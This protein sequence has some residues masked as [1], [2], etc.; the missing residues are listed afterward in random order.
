VSGRQVVGHDPHHG[1][2][3]R[4]PSSDCSVK[5]ADT[6][7]AADRRWHPGHAHPTRPRGPRL[8]PSDGC[9]GDPASEPRRRSVI[10]RW[11]QAPCGAINCLSLIIVSFFPLAAGRPIPFTLAL[12]SSDLAEIGMTTEPHQGVAPRRRAQPDPDEATRSPR[13]VRVAA[14][15]NVPREP[16]RCKMLN[17]L[18]SNGSRALEIELVVGFYEELCGRGHTDEARRSSWPRPGPGCARRRGATP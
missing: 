11:P 4:L 7:P 2:A 15:S 16:I 1:L 14:S 8:G 10:A 9:R 5:C 3:L 12:K 18:S 6:S 17:L 13:L